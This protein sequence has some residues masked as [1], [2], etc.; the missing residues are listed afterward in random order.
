M[1]Q[2][3]PNL[4]YVNPSTGNDSAS[5]SQ[6]TPLKTITKAIQQATAGSSIR[7]TPGTYNASL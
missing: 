4:L 2:T 3:A 6:V 7:L 1:V 5:G